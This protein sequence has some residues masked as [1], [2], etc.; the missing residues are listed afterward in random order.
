MPTQYDEEKLAT[1]SLGEISK[2]RSRKD[3]D[4][5]K[6]APYEHRAYMREEIEANP[7]RAL[8]YGVVI[9]AYS[10]LKI[11]AS[12]TKDNP[13]IGATVKKT[14]LHLSRSTGSHKEQIEAYKGVGEG[15]M[16]AGRD[17]FK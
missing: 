11:L 15:L 12:L 5:N 16:T 9:P 4:H 7:A 1:M 14:G 8:V 10:A 2:L 6:L 3:A 13:L 17:L